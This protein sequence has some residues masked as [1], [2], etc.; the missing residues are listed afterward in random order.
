METTLRTAAKATTWQLSGLAVM[1]LIAYVLTGSIET[2]G[3]IAA[4]STLCGFAAFFLHEKLWSC[5][6]W[7]RRASN[8]G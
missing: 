1:T 6:H 8:A 2:G 3:S 4:V 5:V 7:G